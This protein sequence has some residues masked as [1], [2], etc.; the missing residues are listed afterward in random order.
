METRDGLKLLVGKLISG[1]SG[2]RMKTKLRLVQLSGS[3]L[4][5]LEFDYDR[6]C[7]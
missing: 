5:K 1:K 2:S 4:L 7:F 6:K 3:N